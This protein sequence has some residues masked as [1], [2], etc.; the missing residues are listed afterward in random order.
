MSF[1][2]TIFSIF[3]AWMTVAIAMLWGVLR[4]A[5]RYQPQT[6]HRTADDV[7]WQRNSSIQASI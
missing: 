3:A 5:R 7:S 6:I 1:A 4:I 2:M